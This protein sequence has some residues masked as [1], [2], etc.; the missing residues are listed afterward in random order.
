MKA[1][2]SAREIA[3][4]ANCDVW[5]IP[6][7]DVTEKLPKPSVLFIHDLV[8]SHYPEGLDRK[9]TRK[10]NQIAP[11]RAA[12]ATICAC[13]SSFIRDTDLLG[14]LGL[15]PEKVRMVRPAPPGDFPEVSDERARAMKP[16]HLVRPYL[17]MPAGIR[18]YKNHRILIEALRVLR[19][20]HRESN[21]DLVL[22]GET[23]GRLPRD[24]QAL[25]EEYDLQEHVHILGPV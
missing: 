14:I 8:T 20:R 10:R 3:Q 16:A 5:I 19:D 17:F 6:F 11:A 13:M 23:P 9:W 21:I 18:G 12:E 15:P 7:L 1:R 25:I 4:A 24:L 2:I 22:T